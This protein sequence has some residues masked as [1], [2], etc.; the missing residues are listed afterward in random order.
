MAEEIVFLRKQWE[1]KNTIIAGL[2]KRI[3]TIENILRMLKQR[4]LMQIQVG[5]DMRRKVESMTAKINFVE[6]VVDMAN[7]YSE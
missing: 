4:Y 1:E 3:A 6:E 5:E 2:N 7:R